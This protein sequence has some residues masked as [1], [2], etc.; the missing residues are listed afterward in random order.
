MLIAI[1]EKDC[2]TVQILKD[3]L[4]KESWTVKFFKNSSDLDK[5]KYDVI[6]SNTVEA[7]KNS[8]EFLLMTE[9]VFKKEDLEND[10]I[11]GFVNKNNPLKLFDQLQYIETKLRIKKNA[12]EEY[13]DIKNISINSSYLIDT[14]KQNKIKG[15]SKPR[16]FSNVEMSY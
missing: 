8:E 9:G 3:L 2:N 14:L 12:V 4:T 13:K 11:C 6:V 7:N 16:I 5:I 1:I 10:A 15:C